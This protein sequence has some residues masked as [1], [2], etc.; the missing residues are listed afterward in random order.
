MQN[1]PYATPSANLYGG[2][3]TT[4]TIG[5]EGVA[6]S[7]LLLRRR[8]KPWARFVGVMMIIGASLMFITGI[9]VSLATYSGGGLLPAQGEQSDAYR[10]GAAMG[11]MMM[12]AMIGFLMLYPGLKL[13]RYATEIGVLLREPTV[14]RLDNAL[15]QQRVVW[16][17]SGITTIVWLAIF[18]VALGVAILAGVATRS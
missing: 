8:K 2:A 9:S 17:F 4:L 1:N 12:Y 7:T 11:A 6:E 14:A 15:N 5:P 13:N 10:L 3:G 18:V 16:K